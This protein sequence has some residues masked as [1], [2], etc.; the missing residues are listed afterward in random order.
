MK[1]KYDTKN[2]LKILFCENRWELSID[3]KLK[4]GLEKCK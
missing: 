3:D 2:E 1:P 4:I